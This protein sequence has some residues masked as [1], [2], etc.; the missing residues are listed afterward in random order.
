MIFK[1]IQAR[2]FRNFSEI[3]AKFSPRINFLIGSNGQGKTNLLEALYLF[4]DGDSFRYGDNLVMIRDGANEAFIRVTAE[5]KNLDYS[6]TALIQKSKKTFTANEKKISSSELRKR[7]TSVLFSPE[8]LASIKEGADYRRDLVDQLLVS[9]EPVN[10]D[11]LSEYKKA[12]K[13][14]NKLL[15]DYQDGNTPKNETLA[16]LESLEPS[17]LRLAAQVSIARMVALKSI[18][19]E[20]NA[21]MQDI[22]QDKSVEIS[23]EYSVS[24]ENALEKSL[25]EV[26]NLLHNRLLE[27]RDAELATGASLVGPQKHDIVFLYGQKDSRFYCSQGQQR[28]IILSFKMAQIVYHRRVHGFYPALMLDDV[29]S[30]LDEGKKSALINFLHEINTQIFIT[31]T[32]LTLPE[33]FAMENYSLMKIKN[34]AL[35]T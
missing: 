15:R 28:A 31:T 5:S 21:A 24:G 12:L 22:S 33:S 1:E 17:F 20:F 35:T 29:L 27:L 9:I 7:F 14:R 8:S 16:L 10:A 34:G 30:E 13:T 23:V 6:L 2:N 25:E 32:D 3:S 11:L 19:P 18:L 26:S 4:S